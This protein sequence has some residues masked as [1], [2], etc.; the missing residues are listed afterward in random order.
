VQR[1]PKRPVLADD[2]DDDDE[3]GRLMNVAEYANGIV[4]LMLYLKFSQP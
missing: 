2:D 4:R 1:G 3:K